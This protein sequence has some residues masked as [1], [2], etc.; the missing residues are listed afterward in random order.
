MNPGPFHSPDCKDKDT[1]MLGGHHVCQPQAEN[2][3]ARIQRLEAQVKE[4]A[5]YVDFLMKP[6]T[7]IKCN[8]YN[9]T[10]YHFGSETRICKKCM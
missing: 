2:Q 10:L 6:H 8:A 5:I 4:M 3:E 9:V 1:V 7:C